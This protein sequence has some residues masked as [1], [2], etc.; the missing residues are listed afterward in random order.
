MG[1]SSS[2]DAKL[3]RQ[4][5]IRVDEDDEDAAVQATKF[6]V[7]LVGNS[8][9]GKSRCDIH[10]THLRVVAAFAQLPHCTR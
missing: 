1:C 2:S 7:V 9:V 8:A 4:S 5:G 10:S 6:K 3:R